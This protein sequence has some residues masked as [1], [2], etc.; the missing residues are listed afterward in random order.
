MN[1]TKNPHPSPESPFKGKTGL[2]RVWNAFGYSL[3]GL[4]AAFRLEDAFRQ[5]C[6]LAAIL[7]PAALFVPTNGTGKALLIGSTLLVLIVELLNSAIEATVDRVSLEH[8]QLAKRAKDI[9]SAA[10]LIALVNLAAVWGLV[11]FA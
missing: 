2:V 4:K 7:I 5:E 9:G 3:A 1:S 10:V 8:H 6:L 11:L